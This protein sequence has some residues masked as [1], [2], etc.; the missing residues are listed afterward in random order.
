MSDGTL[1][2]HRLAQVPI[3]LRDNANKKRRSGA[4]FVHVFFIRQY[5]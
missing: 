3:K 4:F 1:T 2:A 5:P